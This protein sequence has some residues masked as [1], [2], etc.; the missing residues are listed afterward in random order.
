MGDSQRALTGDRSAQ[1]PYNAI[2]QVPIYQIDA[3]TSE[4]FS[5]NPAAVCPLEAWLSDGL[6][7]S[8]AAENNLAETAFFV[9]SDRGFQLRWFTP[10]SEV[11]LCGHATLASAY[12]L[13]WLLDYA[14][15]VITFE[16]RSGDLIVARDGEHL[17]MDFP[18]RPPVPC[19]APQSLLQGLSILP[20]E[21]LG[22]D[23]YLLVYE[24]EN[25]VRSLM[26]SFDKL[27]EIDRRGVIVTA[28]GIEYDF[29]SRFFAPKLGVPE[30]PV[31]GS[32]H[33]TLA[34]FWGERLDKERMIAAQL[35]KRGGEVFCEPIGE[36]V[37]LSGSAVK[38]MEGRI[39]LDLADPP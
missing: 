2:V 34:P 21:T 1:S 9:A 24:H 4:A 31:T 10:T 23:D 39:S 3:F 38:F 8:I 7:Q 18:A 28:P 6:M 29:V 20:A 12:V 14:G 30:D 19:E 37:L 17:R 32:A 11:E 16:T 27:A 5:G 13:Y 22:A 15:D 33:C 25:D 35:S 36:R 26:V